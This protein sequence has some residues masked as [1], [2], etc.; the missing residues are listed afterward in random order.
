M[1]AGVQKLR[2]RR[3]CITTQKIAR[4]DVTNILHA[5]MPSKNGTVIRHRLNQQREWFDGFQYLLTAAT[6]LRWQGQQYSRNPL[7]CH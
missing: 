4:V 1:N 2:V 6:C 5:R 3:H 7:V